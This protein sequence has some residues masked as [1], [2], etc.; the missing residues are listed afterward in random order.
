MFIPVF[1]LNKG[2]SLYQEAYFAT[3]FSGTSPDRPLYKEPPPPGQEKKSCVALTDQL[4]LKNK[5]KKKQN[6]TKIGLGMHPIFDR[7]DVFHLFWEKR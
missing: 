2:S 6:K 5:I 3:H 4:I 1:A 7:L